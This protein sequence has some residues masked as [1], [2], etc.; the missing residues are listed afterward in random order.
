MKSVADTVV[1]LQ[2]IELN[3][4][5]TRLLV[6]LQDDNSG[7]SLLVYVFCLFSERLINF[8]WF[9]LVTINMNVLP[10]IWEFLIY[11]LFWLW[12]MFWLKFIKTL[13]YITWFNNLKS[14]FLNSYFV[15]ITLPI[16]KNFV[17][18][19]LSYLLSYNKIVRRNID[20]NYSFFSSILKRNPSS[21]PFKFVSDD[22]KD[23]LKVKFNFGLLKPVKWEK[24]VKFD[25]IIHFIHKTLVFTP[26]AFK[27]GN[28]KQ[29]YFKNYF[30]SKKRYNNWIWKWRN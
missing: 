16:I 10:F 21:E 25:K 26:H 19:Y 11:F 18:L 12:F 30:N 6:E 29:A 23:W 24:V 4:C 7:T 1:W 20:V 22:F 3:L 27:F 28:R 14:L 17:Y 8:T 9:T 15:V 13:R 5:I 2:N